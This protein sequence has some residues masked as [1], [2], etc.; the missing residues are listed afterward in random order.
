MNMTMR[1][2]MPGVVA[3]LVVATGSA[4]AFSGGV[5]ST[6]LGP[7]GCNQCHTG[8]GA[9]TVK[10][11]G[12]KE[13]DPGST[14]EYRLSIVVRGNQ[15]HGGLNARAS[16]GQLS[17]G[18]EFSS[19]TRTIAGAAGNEITQ[20]AAKLA[21]VWN[22]VE[23]TFLWTAPDSF[24]SMTLDVWGNGVDNNGAATGDGASFASLEVVPAGTLPREDPCSTEVLPSSPVSVTDPGAQKCQAS[25]AKGG[26]AYTKGV[27]KVMQK[28]LQDFHRWGLRGEAYEVCVG[29]NGAAP[30]DRK[31]WEK[32][33]A[34]ETKA[35]NFIDTQCT[36]AMVAELGLCGR[37]VS[38]LKKC[39]AEEHR[40]VV[41]D[42]L[43]RQFGDLHQTDNIEL[44]K[45][46]K[47]ISKASAKFIATELKVMQKCLTEWNKR[48]MA[49]DAAELCLGSMVAGRF[50]PPADA[51]TALAINKAESK[52][53]AKVL[54]ACSQEQVSALDACSKQVGDLGKCL[55][56][57]HRAGSYQ[58]V[59]ADYAAAP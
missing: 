38:D 24:S 20:S 1:W 3:F 21:D 43:R 57:S 45:C 32:F 34:A 52:L 56:C 28:C 54:E 42:L 36:N 9:P 46:Q 11:V 12:P 5:P 19:Q 18:G 26:L 29:K 40:S 55:I 2:S 30:T 39:F 6:V 8:G 48:T 58:V 23:F 49:D 7:S 17:V 16:Q 44:R 35:L 22:E 25:I 37:T 50:V 33:A 41:E 27:L 10:L 47:V 15:D 59:G 51:R 53:N 4:Y 13:V 14:N 31:T